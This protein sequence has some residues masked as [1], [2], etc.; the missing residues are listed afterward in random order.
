MTT[1]ELCI[2]LAE[3]RNKV[4]R[5]LGARYEDHYKRYSRNG[6]LVLYFVL[7]EKHLNW[8]YGDE[9]SSLKSDPNF[10]R[11][12]HEGNVFSKDILLEQITQR[13]MGAHRVV[14]SELNTHIEQLGR[15]HCVFLCSKQNDKLTYLG[16]V[17]ENDDCYIPE[18]NCLDKSK[19]NSQRFGTRHE[20]IVYMYGYYQALEN[21][22]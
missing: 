20:A 16:K 3:I 15:T 19:Y 1:G 13:L 8:D 6:S 5:H 12:E 11:Y 10:V 21:L 9:S 7:S 18:L 2:R 22:K 14:P 4:K 17:I